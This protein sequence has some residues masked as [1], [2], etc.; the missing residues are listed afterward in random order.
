MCNSR[1]GTARLQERPKETTRLT[2]E[3]NIECD[4]R[5]YVKLAARA[6]KAN[7]GQYSDIRGPIYKISYDL[8]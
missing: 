5:S 4:G 1:Q 3:L 7:V 6:S 2:R 8:L